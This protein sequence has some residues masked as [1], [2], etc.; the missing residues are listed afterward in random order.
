M[1][2]T[3]VPCILACCLLALWTVCSL[4]VLVQSQPPANSN[5]TTNGTST[6][7]MTETNTTEP[8]VANYSNS[9]LEIDD[10][11]CFVR[12]SST[13]TSLEEAIFTTYSELRLDHD[14]PYNFFTLKDLYYS[15]ILDSR[16]VGALLPPPMT[17]ID[18][19]SEAELS[20][21]RERCS[22]LMNRY[23][24]PTRD[25]EGCRWNYRCVQNQLHFP[26]FHVE[27]ILDSESTGICSS[28]SMENRRF[29]RTLCRLNEDLPH[30][31]RCDCGSIVIGYKVDE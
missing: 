5:E 1:F 20:L 30:W 28:I 8:T 7:S 3:T 16:N 2:K 13:C 19:S 27:A 29:V 21:T 17:G 6:Q 14:T 12:E 22:D 10:C 31:L 25:T 18:F 26:S 15:E 24:L 4:S 23:N 9:I 11:T